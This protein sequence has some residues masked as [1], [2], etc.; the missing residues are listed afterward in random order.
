MALI[1]WQPAELT[2]LRHDLDH[3]FDT[4]WTGGQKTAPASGTWSPSIDISE[5]PEAYLVTAEVP[6]VDKKDVQVTVLEN[7][8]LIKGEK[9]SEVPGEKQ[10]THRV[11]RGFGAFSRS[12][13]LPRAVEAEK[14]SASYK[15]GVLRISVPKAEE[16]KPKQIEINVTDASRRSSAA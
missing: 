16:A 4:L 15:D 1:H 2:G 6:G 10:N 5:T 12:F 13:D 14:I 3:V 9:Q 8:L 7:R 11:E